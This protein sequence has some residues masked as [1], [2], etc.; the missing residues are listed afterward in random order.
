MNR[1][2]PSTS[3]RSP[4]ETCS[5]RCQRLT[6]RPSAIRSTTWRGRLERIAKRPETYVDVAHTPDSARAVAESLA[7]I[8]PLLDPAQSVVLFGCLADKRVDAILDS[9]APLA[10]TIVVAPVRSGRGA[11]TEVLKRSATGRFPTVVVAPDVATG[12]GLAK[13]AVGPD[14]ILLATGS[15]Y[16]VGEVLDAV[17]GRGDDEPDLSDPGLGGLL[18]DPGEPAR[19]KRASRSRA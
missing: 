15:D 1:C 12:F 13:V 11:P 18:P 16:L 8:R 10:R 14:G 3:V 7:E 19:P 9:L 2:P 4:T 17:E 6:P 5:P